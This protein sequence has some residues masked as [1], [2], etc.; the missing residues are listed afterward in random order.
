MT[1][2]TIEHGTGLRLRRLTGSIGAEVTGVDVRAADDATA[3]AVARLVEEHGVLFFR[4]QSTDPADLTRFASLLGPLQPAHPLKPGLAGH[5]HVLANQTGGVTADDIRC[6]DRY[7]R[8][9]TNW[10]VDC[11]FV[12]DVPVYSLLQAVT[13]QP[14]GGDTLFADLAGAYSGLSRPL[15]DLA[16]RLSCPHDAKMLY[17]DWLLPGRDQESRDRLLALPVVTHPLVAV[18]PQTG[19]RSLVLNPNCV[20]GIEGF[21]QLESDTLLDLFLA[22]TLVPE[23][24]VRW[25]WDEGDIAVWDNV[26]LLHNYVLD[27]GPGERLIQRAMAG[28]APLV[29]PEGGTSG[30]LPSA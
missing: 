10:H 24:T 12:R 9:A 25:K 7:N 8:H 21:S 3:D 30:A 6:R 15:Q 4:G 20:T 23:R 29:G 18:A 1:R 11:T 17:A 26:R 27:N 13:V 28:A 2:S 16:S 19:R 5:P 14:F 22:H